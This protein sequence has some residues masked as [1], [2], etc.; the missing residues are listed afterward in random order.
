MYSSHDIVATVSI[1]PIEGLE[2][3]RR[4]EAFRK[5]GRREAFIPSL[6]TVG[7][8]GFIDSGGTLSGIRIAA[9]GGSGR[10]QR[11]EE[12]EKLLEGNCLPEDLL[13]EVYEA[14]LRQFEISDDAFVT[15][16]YKKKT[17][18]NLI[19]AELWSQ[20]HASAIDAP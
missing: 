19:A 20:I 6:V 4:F 3:M 2:G 9:G 17:A 12:A 8:A 7:L 15:A 5:V 13:P 1:A 11:L 16:E 14:V 18:A 10:P